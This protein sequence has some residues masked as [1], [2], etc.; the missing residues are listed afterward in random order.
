MVNEL[1]QVF[2][3]Y[4]LPKT[5][6]YWQCQ[7][8]GGNCDQRLGDV[9]NAIARVLREIASSKQRSLEKITPRAARRRYYLM[10]HSLIAP[11]KAVSLFHRTPEEIHVLAGDGEV[12]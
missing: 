6:Q 4:V 11:D 9:Q 8:I 10:S 7:G 5:K 1:N 3:K 12:G 2:K